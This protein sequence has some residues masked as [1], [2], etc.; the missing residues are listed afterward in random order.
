LAP[1]A[2][3]CAITLALR[4]PARAESPADDDI[5]VSV[6]TFGPGDAVHQYFGHNAIVVEG[7][8]VPEPTVF[9]YG[10]FS[11]GPDMLPQFLT[12]R[13]KFWLGLSELERTVSQYAAA[14]RDVRLLELNL[15]PTQ[16]K[17]VLA[18]LLRDSRPQNREYLYDHYF[19]NCSTRVRDVLD[20]ALHGQLRRA[21][22]TRAPFTLRQETM[23][24]TQRDPLVEWSMMFALNGSVDRSQTLW[25][26]AF[27]PLQLETLL[28]YTTYLDENADRIPLV[29]SVS[30]LHRAQRAPLP[31]E[32][33]ERWPI[34]LGIGCAIGLVFLLLGE[35]ARSMPKPFHA[36]LILGTAIYG[37]VGGL[38]GTLVTYLAI[39]SDHT[40]TH[41]NANLLLLNPLTLLAGLL[42]ASELVSSAGSKLTQLIQR[43]ADAVWFVACA[44]SVTLLALKL[45]PVGFEQDVAMTTSLLLPINVAIA[46]ARIRLPDPQ[47]AVSP[48]WVSQSS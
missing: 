5:K 32:P 28:Q 3:W 46:L 27:L 12:G 19:D 24:H 13:L 48:A 44:S 22:S 2:A 10:M 43:S 1:L 35:R 4:A 42:S 40:V 38:L 39:F 14:N 17:V 20:A 37:C 41:G 18:R 30:V 45:A 11:F 15:T 26:D 47:H 21:W 25:A 29:G 6:V 23:R 8:R 16:R 31:A 7:A 33:E 9:N 36:L 34:A